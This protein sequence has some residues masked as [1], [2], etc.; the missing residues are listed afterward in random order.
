MLCSALAARER[1]ER[2]KDMEGTYGTGP[3]LFRCYHR[4][5]PSP[6][7]SLCP[8]PSAAG[9]LSVRAPRRLCG[10]ERLPEPA[11]GRASGGRPAEP[12]EVRASPG[13]G[14]RR[15][16]GEGKKRSGGK[17]GDS[18]ISVAVGTRRAP[19]VGLRRPGGRGLG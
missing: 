2:M 18:Q 16:P 13:V 14:S 9:A 5:H 6:S 15:V 11:A 7:R 19:R 12:T 4:L 17:K 3:E 10:S 8:A 1:V